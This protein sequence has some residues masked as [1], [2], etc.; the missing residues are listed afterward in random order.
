MQIQGTFSSLLPLF[1]GGEVEGRRPNHSPP[2]GE[3]NE[4]QFNGRNGEEGRE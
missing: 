4:M 2:R 3:R 1:K